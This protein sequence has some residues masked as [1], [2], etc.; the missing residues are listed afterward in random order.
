MD[1]L[2][3]DHEENKHARSAVDNT[4]TYTLLVEDIISLTLPD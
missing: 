1:S 3:S 2:I 4:I